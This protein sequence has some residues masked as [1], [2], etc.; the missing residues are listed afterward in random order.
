M[1]DALPLTA[2]EFSELRPIHTKR[3]YVRLRL[4]TDV[5]ERRRAWCEWAFRLVFAARLPPVC[6]PAAVSTDKLITVAQPAVGRGLAATAVTRI[7]SSVIFASNIFLVIVSV[8]IR[9]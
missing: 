8:I 4:S 5:D 3:V 1:C 9:L 6:L 2:T 7:G